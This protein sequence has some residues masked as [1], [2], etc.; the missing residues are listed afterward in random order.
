MPTL[1]S[2][3]SRATPTLADSP[4]QIAAPRHASSK[5]QS[6]VIQ[7]RAPSFRVAPSNRELQ[8]T[9][10]SQIPTPTNRSSTTRAKPYS[11]TSS[12][13]LCQVKL[14]HYKYFI[15]KGYKQ[16]SHFSLVSETNNYITN[17]RSNKPTTSI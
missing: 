4:S 9:S 11:R 6:R 13:R 15:P 3:K 12:Q 2:S 5:H 7:S 1:A 8:V 17:W 10:P 16:L 14:A